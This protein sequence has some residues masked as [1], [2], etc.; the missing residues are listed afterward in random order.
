MGI[1][2]NCLQ[3]R[4]H[5]EKSLE[6]TATSMEAESSHP[7]N[8]VAVARQL[9]IELDRWLAGRPDTQLLRRAWLDRAEPLGQHIHLRQGGEDFIGRTID[10]DPTA[11]LIVQLD[12]GGR[13]V[14]DPAT[15]TLV[16]AGSGLQPGS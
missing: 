14:F 3:H 5:F 13:R 16:R 7:V 8:R 15:T 4:R 2:V 10:V 1:G 9:L 11:A 6:R 12:G